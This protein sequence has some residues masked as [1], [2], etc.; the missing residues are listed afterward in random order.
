MAN[1]LKLDIKEPADELKTRFKKETNAQKKERLHALYL[2]KS[3]KVTTLESLSRLLSRDTSTLYRWFQKYKHEG[4]D[5]LLK[6]Y[7]PA[8]RPITIPPEA[9]EK[10]KL[11]IQSNEGFNSYGEIQSWL[12]EACGVDVDYHVVYRA[13]R[14][15]F[16]GKFKSNR[17]SRSRRNSPLSALQ[18]SSFN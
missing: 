2:L 15:K 9:L 8:G 18:I 13:V 4:L 11:R 10:L 3:G 5:G 14:Y 12:K 16:Q 7:K 17:R 1:T 6:V